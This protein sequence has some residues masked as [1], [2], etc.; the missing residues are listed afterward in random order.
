MASS[1]IKIMFLHIGVEN[2]CNSTKL[3]R[4]VCT[5]YIYFVKSSCLK[6]NTYLP[7]A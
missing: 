4:L 2:I 1:R 5:I 7:E 3:N 6:D